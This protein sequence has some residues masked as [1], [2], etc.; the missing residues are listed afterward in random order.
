M[1]AFGVDYIGRVQGSAHRLLCVDWLM[2][3]LPGVAAALACKAR[4]VFVS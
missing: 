1:A 2:G 3:L 4:T